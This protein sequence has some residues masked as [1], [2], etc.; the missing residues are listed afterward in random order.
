MLQRIHTKGT[1]RKSCVYH[2]VIPP[3]LGGIS[4]LLHLLSGNITPTAQ[5]TWPPVHKSARGAL[6]F[7]EQHY[8]EFPAPG[9]PTSLRRCRRL[10]FITLWA[11]EEAHA[12]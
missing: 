1:T 8:R 6:P 9:R 7:R 4:E 2:Y 5:Q 10:F 12:R 11:E 3:T